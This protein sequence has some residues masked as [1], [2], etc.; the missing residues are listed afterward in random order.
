MRINEGV[1]PELTHTYTRACVCVY[2]GVL[3]YHLYAAV[4]IGDEAEQ[5]LREQ[6][7]QGGGRLGP[8][9]QLLQHG[10]NTLPA[11]RGDRQHQ[12][13]LLLFT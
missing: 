5:F 10:Q 12:R 2:V 4:V 11:Q 3:V 13:R 9:Q 8:T 7:H 1:S 6:G